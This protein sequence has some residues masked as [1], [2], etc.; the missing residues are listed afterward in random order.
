MDLLPVDCLRIIAAEMASHNGKPR[1]VCEVAADAM[2][3][4]LTGSE[5]LLGLSACVQEVL[6]PG[7][8]QQVM[9]AFELARLHADITMAS[10]Q[11]TLKAAC[12]VRGLRVTGTKAELL[13]R[14]QAAQDVARPLYG[15]H[16]TATFRRSIA[17]THMLHPARIADTLA[18]PARIERAALIAQELRTLG[19]KGR[20]M[21]AACVSLQMSFICSARGGGCAKNVASGILRIHDRKN[22]LERCLTRKGCELR[23]DSRLCRSFIE[24]GHGCPEDIAETMEEMK[25]YHTHTKY[26]H[27]LNWLW[28]NARQERAY[29]GY[30]ERVDADD[31]S[32]LAQSL[33]LKL[34]AKSNDATTAPELPTSLRVAA[35]QLQSGK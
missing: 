26:N 27:I 19:V 14:L 4:V 21:Y 35:R 8:R 20:V 3:L 18:C 25:F 16:L 32:S 29:F 5:G 30:R 22:V 2:N 23:S 12:Q 10:L 6:Q 17:A 1:S 7:G 33:A 28:D 9:D 24:H 31:M 11:K 15:C 13:A 34:W